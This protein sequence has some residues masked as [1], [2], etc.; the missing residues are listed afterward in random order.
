MPALDE[1][2][3]QAALALWNYLR[4]GLPPEPADLILVMGSH[5][6]RV[7]EHGARLWLQGYAPLLL[8]SGGLGNFTRQL[9]DEPEAQKFARIA[10][11]LGVPD[12]ALLIE[13]RSTNTGENVAFSRALLAERGIAPHKVLLVQKPYMERRALATFLRVWPGI[14]VFPS[15]PPIDFDAYPTTE[16]PLERVIGIMVGD[17]Q[18]IL[19]YP[20]YGYQIPQAVSESAIQAYRLL[21]A[22]GFTAHLIPNEKVEPDSLITVQ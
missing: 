3:H 16:I 12:S 6:L 9:W 5:D 1:A 18:R 14:T 19:F 7:A 17:F 22:A 11:Q 21:V 8:M 20:H 15:S 10:R 13:P 2:V 4:L